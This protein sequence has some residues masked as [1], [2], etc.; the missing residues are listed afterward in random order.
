MKCQVKEEENVLKDESTL[1]YFQGRLNLPLKRKKVREG[2]SLALL[3]IWDSI[4]GHLFNLIQVDY[5][6]AFVQAG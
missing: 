6:I 3:Q 1:G 2:E 5:W 4:L